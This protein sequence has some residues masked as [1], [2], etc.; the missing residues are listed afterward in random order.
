M[1]YPV[2]TDPKVVRDLQRKLA[3]TINQHLLWAFNPQY[4]QPQSRP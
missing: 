3:K 1:P 2:A 4:P